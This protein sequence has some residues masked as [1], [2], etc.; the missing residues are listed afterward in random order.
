MLIIS[1]IAIV[2]VVC[3]VLYRDFEDSISNDEEPPMY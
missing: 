1:F 2:A 3:Y